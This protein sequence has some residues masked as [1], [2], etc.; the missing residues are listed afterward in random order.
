MVV[1]C[2]NFGSLSWLRPGN[3][4]ADPFRFNEHAAAFN[5]TGFAKGSKERRFWHTPGVV[6]MNVGQ[7]H[8]IIF[9]PGKYQTTGIER[10][11]EW[12]RV[13][14]GRSMSDA[15]TPD[16]IILCLQSGA[17]GRIDF[18]SSWHNGDIRVIAGSA[19]RGEQETLLMGTPGAIFRTEKGQWEVTWTGLSSK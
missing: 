7:Q 15:T 12:S 4:V 1:L 17:V 6:R 11:G 16:G 2:I 18:D 19:F 5:T 13:L 10:R 8:G 3:D 9:R 14:L